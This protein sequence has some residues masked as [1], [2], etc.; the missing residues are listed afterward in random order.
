MTIEK[1]GTAAGST[2]AT[3]T[4]RL[5]IAG[6]PLDVDGVVEPAGLRQRLPD[7]GKGAAQLH[8]RRAL[9]VGQPPGEFGGRQRAGQNR[10]HV[11]VPDQRRPGRG[12]GRGHRGHPWDD[13]GRETRP[14]SRSCRYM[15]EP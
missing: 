4:H 8:D 9:G 3:G 2:S 14:L 5:P 7:G 15:Y 10:Q 11:L 6:R 12:C 13:L 1:Y